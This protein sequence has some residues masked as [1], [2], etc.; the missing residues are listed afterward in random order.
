M[1]VKKKL[2]SLRYRRHALRFF[3]GF[4]SSSES[5]PLRARTG[6]TAVATRDQSGGFGVVCD[7]FG[8]KAGEP[9]TYGGVPSK[10][11]VGECSRRNPNQRIWE[12]KGSGGIKRSSR[13]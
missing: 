6:H 2:V 1:Y 5:I 12:L 3:R 7:I 4:S 11:R 9:G 8:E 10:G 13:V